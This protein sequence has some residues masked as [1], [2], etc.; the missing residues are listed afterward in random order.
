MSANNPSTHHQL[1]FLFGN[2][3]ILLYFVLDKDMV[4]WCLEAEFQ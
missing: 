1:T 3:Y 4:L 2:L